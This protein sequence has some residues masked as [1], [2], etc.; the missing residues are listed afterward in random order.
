[1]KMRG[2]ILGVLFLSVVVVG[3]STARNSITG[4]WRGSDQHYTLKFLQDGK[5]E[6]AWH[7]VDPSNKSRDWGRWKLDGQHIL[8]TVERR[9]VDPRYQPSRLR[10]LP[11]TVKMDVTEM[12]DS[13]LVFLNE[14]GEKHTLKRNTE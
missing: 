10:P 5:F 8:V 2:C 12:T 1:M 3:C 7:N 4:S 13:V 14:S 6:R 9:R 11:Y